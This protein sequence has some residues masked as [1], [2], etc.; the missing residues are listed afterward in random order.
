MAL[1][2]HS[3]ATIELK[4]EELAQLFDN[5]DPFPF[6]DRDLDRKA[7]E[8]IVGWAREI[9]LRRSIAIVIHAPDREVQRADAGQRREAISRYFANR[10]QSATL[11]LKETFRLGRRALVVGMLVLA[12]CLLGGKLISGRIGDDYV[13]RFVTESLVIVGWVANWRPLEIFLY[14]W[15]PIVRKRRLYGRLAK[16]SVLLKRY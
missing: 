3:D 13:A 11:E 5:L 12:I 15:W 2:G 6:P 4:V 8:Y 1:A 10:I 9:P 7:E 16:A 14:D